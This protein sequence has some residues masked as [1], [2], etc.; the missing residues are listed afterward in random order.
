[1][2]SLA[3]LK[4]RPSRPTSSRSVSH[5]GEIRRATL[6]MDKARR[7]QNGKEKEVNKAAPIPRKRD[8]SE[9]SRDQSERNEGRQSK[10]LVTRIEFFQ[11][12]ELEHIAQT[13]R[14]QI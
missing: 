11:L 8:I 10:K 3:K 14:V 5:R 9:K 7:A 12:G 1:M 2:S 4:A 13:I 6:A